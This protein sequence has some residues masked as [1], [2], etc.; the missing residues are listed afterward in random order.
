V[1]LHS[2]RLQKGT[3]SNDALPLQVEEG[4]RDQYESVCAYALT[5]RA[6]QHFALAS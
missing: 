5:S 3:H 6:K 2:L 4:H 1:K